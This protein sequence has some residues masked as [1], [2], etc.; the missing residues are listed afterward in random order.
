M[1]THWAVKPWAKNEAEKLHLVSHKKL[2]LFL[3]LFGLDEETEDLAYY[4]ILLN[5]GIQVFIF[6]FIFLLIFLSMGP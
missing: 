6:L 3:D 2:L 1:T 4:L 5:Q